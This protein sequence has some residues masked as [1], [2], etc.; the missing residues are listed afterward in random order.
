MAELKYVP[1]GIRL[2]AKEFLYK[3]QK[4]DLKAHFYISFDSIKSGLEAEKLLKNENISFYAIPVPDEIFDDCGVAL[5]VE[6]YEQI[7][8]LLELKGIE[9]EVHH[10]QQGNVK[11]VYGDIAIKGSCSIH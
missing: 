8:K 1:D 11:K 10:Y 2:H 9:V 6:E 4:K 5:V 3:L 7:C